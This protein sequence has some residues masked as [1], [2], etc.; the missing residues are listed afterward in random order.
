ME[1]IEGTDVYRIIAPFGVTGGIIFNSGVTDKEVT[2][3]KD[4]YQTTDLP[5][6]FDLKG[7]IY[8]IDMSSE[9]KADP[10]AMKSKRRYSEGSWSDYSEE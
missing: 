7:K 3:G 5:Y 2:E 4:A 1:Q 6:S 10:G 9:P 8:K